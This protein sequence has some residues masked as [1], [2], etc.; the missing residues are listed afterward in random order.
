MDTDRQR[1]SDSPHMMPRTSWLFRTASRPRSSYAASSFGSNDLNSSNNNSNGLTRPV[2][3]YEATIENNYMVGGEIPAT[4]LPAAIDLLSTGPNNSNAS[5][6]YSPLVG[7]VRPRQPSLPFNYAMGFDESNQHNYSLPSTPRSQVFTASS[8]NRFFNE[9]NE[10]NWSATMNGAIANGSEVYT[11]LESHQ[12]MSSELLGPPS[13]SAESLMQQR[14]YEYYGFSVYLISIIL[15]VLF[16]LWAYLPDQVLI[17][18]GIAYFPSKHWAIAFPAWT[19]MLFL[20]IYP[21]FMSIN[22][23]RTPSL[24]AYNTITDEFATI[25]S[26]GERTATAVVDDTIE[27]HDLP[28]S[29]VNACLYGRDDSSDNEVD[30]DDP[31]ST[32]PF[33][34]SGVPQNKIN[35]RRNSDMDDTLAQHNF[36]L[37]LLVKPIITTGVSTNSSA[38]TLST[39]WEST[40]A[41]GTRDDDRSLEKTSNGLHSDYDTPTLL[42]SQCHHQ[43]HHH[44]RRIPR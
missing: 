6:T 20:F 11:S 8:T 10:S 26:L 33:N 5:S 32:R 31:S 1:R 14:K 21:V 41:I 42:L 19:M 17:N 37:D 43:I 9:P 27:L 39:S 29:V 23:M 4:G 3:M 38:N 40:T 7:N 24:D 30:T 28:I 2:T 44:C 25:R 13:I 16:S 35:S 15:A 22:L 12:P 18:V 34:Y 36:N